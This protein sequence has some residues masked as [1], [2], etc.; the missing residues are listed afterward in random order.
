[1][2]DSSIVINNIENIVVI[3]IPDYNIVSAP[4]ASHYIIGGISCGENWQRLVDEFSSQV[5]G[6]SGDYIVNIRVQYFIKHFSWCFS[7]RTSIVAL[8][9]SY[10]ITLANT[11][12]F[13]YNSD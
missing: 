5:A 11:L 7:L 10:F 6:K 4:I 13:V 12:R 8:L 2:S 3:T 1:M 9:Q